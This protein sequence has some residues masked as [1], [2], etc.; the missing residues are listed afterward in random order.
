MPIRD[1]IIWGSGNPFSDPRLI[2]LDEYVKSLRKGL[3]LPNIRGGGIFANALLD[4]P[5][6][7]HGYY[8]EYDVEPTV[9]GKDRGLLRLVLGN[10]GE[11]YITGNH[12]RDFRQII[13][14]PV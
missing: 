5:V 13:N 14:M 12:Y 9:K 11:V 1:R 3:L 8:R 7:R 2:G 6:K 10:G 4:L